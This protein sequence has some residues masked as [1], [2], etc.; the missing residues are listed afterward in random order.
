M[1][2]RRLRAFEVPHPS[3]KRRDTVR[4]A[5][6]FHVHGDD[7]PTME[8]AAMMADKNAV[9]AEHQA[10]A[11]DVANRAATRSISNHAVELVNSVTAVL[12]CSASSGISS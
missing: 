8:L 4:T 3:R 7:E 1:R 10:E 2:Q 12:S 11:L 6:R 5:A 9:V